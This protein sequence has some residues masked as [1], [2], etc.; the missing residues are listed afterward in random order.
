M[1]Y[2]AVKKVL[3]KSIALLPPEVLSGVS[4]AFLSSLARES[5]GKLP[6]NKQGDG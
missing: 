2:N 3:Y 1:D 4:G 5:F 6:A